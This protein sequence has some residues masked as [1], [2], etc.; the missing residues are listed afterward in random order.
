MT[1][2]SPSARR[3]HFLLS[4]QAAQRPSAC[5]LHWQGQAIDYADLQTRVS[6]LAGRLAATGQPGDR[7]AV[8]AWN[9]PE[10]LE[11]IYACAASGRV[12]VPLNARLA[13]AELCYQLQSSGTSLLFGDPLLLAPLLAHQQYP[14]EIRVVALNDEYRHWLQAGPSQSLPD[15]VIDDPV[16]ILYTSGSTG[17]PKGAVITHQSFLAGL[18]SAAQGRPVAPDDTYYY[19]FPLFHIAAHNVLLQHQYGACVVLSRSFD[20]GDTLRACRELGITTLSLAPTMMAMLVDH[21][22]FNPDDLRGVRTIG[23]GASAMPQVLLHRL[24]KQTSVGLCQSYGMTELSG[25]ISFLTPEDH[26]YAA[27][28]QPDR[29]N[30]V[31]RPLPCVRV[32]I[33]DDCGQRVTAGDC[34]EILVQARQCF[35]RYWQD[36]QNTRQALQQGWLHTGDIGRFDPQGY[37]YI[38]DRKKDMVLSG[39]ENVASREVEE[40]LRKHPAVYDCAIIGLPDP[41]WGESVCAVLTEKSPVSDTVL[42]AH[43]REFLAG[44]KIP[45]QWIRVAQLP[46]NAG[47][48]IDKPLLR[49]QASERTRDAT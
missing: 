47:G 9:C 31:G 37:L 15:T 4:D 18:D 7:V 32:K 27:E 25:S 6:R 12:L 14:G 42:A 22:D 11:L 16:W 3:L 34:G 8:L 44:Y 28:C 23:Y 36:P 24:L 33:V 35:S 10:F 2:S 5:A 21:P 13:P 17:R 30:S 43:C 48:K 45:R 26:R 40:V 20:A 39:G 46:V 19:P 41:K 1:T 29:L 49:R 38:V